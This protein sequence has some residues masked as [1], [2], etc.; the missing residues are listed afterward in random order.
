M[1]DNENNQQFVEFRNLLYCILWSMLRHFTEFFI[2]IFIFYSLRF[3]AKETSNIE[4][5]RIKFF[6]KNILPVD[7]SPVRW[8][9]VLY[10][11]T[12]R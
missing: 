2:L 9:R 4:V 11:L 1:Q 12:R 3:L 7:F 5:T 6:V 10:R 8:P